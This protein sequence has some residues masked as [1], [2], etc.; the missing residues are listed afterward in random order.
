MQTP[1]I[2]SK[3][4]RGQSMLEFAFGFVVLLL[5]LS[6]AVD[7]GRALF[8]YMAL[9]DSAQE[10]ALYGS[11]NPTATGEI[12]S[13]VKQ[14]SDVLQSLSSQDPAHLLVDVL[15][16][17]EGCTGDA[18]T[19]KVTYDNFQITMPLLGG[20]IGSQSIGI[21]ASVTDTILSPACH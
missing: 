5:M 7:G 9:R 18:L 10:G 20:F 4:E 1:R 13:R 2:K 8:T 14:S 16:G 21:S 17:G 12:V 6:G 19:V 3:S 11:T 15:V